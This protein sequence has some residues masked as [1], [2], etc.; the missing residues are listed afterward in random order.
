MLVFP[1]YESVRWS[2]ARRDLWGEIELKAINL[3]SRTDLERAQ[4][5]YAALP[6]PQYSKAQKPSIRQNIK[7]LNKS[8]HPVAAIC[9]RYLDDDA[10][11]R[12]QS[13]NR[14]CRDGLSRGTVEVHKESVRVTEGCRGDRNVHSIWNIRSG[15]CNSSSGAT[16][17]CVRA[18][19]H[20]NRHRNTA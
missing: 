4:W 5:V 8:I 6:A 12:G 17:L 11:L 16:R 15:T 20:G 2:R 10:L 13:R 3:H 1:E 9:A 18:V 19:G 14:T 7:R